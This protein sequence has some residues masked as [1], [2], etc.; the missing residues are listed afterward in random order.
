MQYFSNCFQETLRKIESNPQ[1][2][3]QTKSYIEL[4]CIATSPIQLNISTLSDLHSLFVPLTSSLILGQDY[5]NE[6][7]FRALVNSR[8]TYYFVDLKFVDIYYLKIST[9]PPVAL[10]LFDGSLNSTIS[11]I[12]N[13]PIIFPT[14]NYMNLNFYITPVNSSYSLVLGYNW[15]A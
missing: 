9:T 12:A 7:L 4:P 10:H 13:M 2:S 1:N 3:I 8:S 6:I 11:K 15:L 5:L 14:S